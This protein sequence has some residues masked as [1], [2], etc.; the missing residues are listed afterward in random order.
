MQKRIYNFE[1]I[2]GVDVTSSPI[3]VAPNRAS[4]MINMISEGGTNKK[5]HGW[6]DVA[7]FDYSAAL[8]V[9]DINTATRPPI[10]GIFK[11]KDKFV[12]HAGTRFFLCEA[13]NGAFRADSLIIT[14]GHPNVENRKSKG[15]VQGDKLW[16][17]GAGDYLVYDGE[18]IQP[19]MNSE[20]AFIPTTTVGIKA[21]EYGGGGSR[22]Q[23]VNLL[24]KRRKNKLEGMVCDAGVAY[25]YGYYYLDAEFDE[26]ESVILTINSYIKKRTFE[27]RDGSKFEYEGNVCIEY[28]GSFNNYGNFESTATVKEGDTQLLDWL[29]EITHVF[30]CRNKNK[31]GEVY[32]GNFFST[33]ILE[34]ES[35]I[36]VEFTAKSEKSN[37]FSCSTE[38]DAGKNTLLAVVDEENTVYFSEFYEGYGYFPDNDFIC[39]GEANEPIT[40]LAPIDNCLGIFKKKALYRVQLNISYDDVNCITKTEYNLLQLLKGRG[41]INEYS[42]ASVNGDTVVYDTDGVFGIMASGFSK[43]SSN[44]DSEITARDDA[45]AVSYEGRY[46][47][48]VDGM[49]FIADSRFKYY[50]SNR[51]DSSYEYEWWVWDNCRCRCAFA[52]DGCLYMGTDDGKIRV[53]TDEYNDITGKY[54]HEVDGDVVRYEADMG[55]FFVFDERLKVESG[56]LFDLRGIY[57]K[58][59]KNRISI[60]KVNGGLLSCTFEPSDFQRVKD[61]VPRY[62]LFLYSKN[63]N[64]H[65]L[66]RLEEVVASER[67]L[68]FKCN[69]AYTVGDEYDLVRHATEYMIR[70]VGGG[71]ILS[72]EFNQIAFFTNQNSISGII[73]RKVPV[74]C[75][76]VTGAIDLAVLH[77]KSLYKLAVMPTSDTVG[78]ISFGYTTNYNNVEHKRQVGRAL[79]FSAFDFN[80]FVFDGAYFKTFIRRVF[81]RNFNLITLRFASSSDGPFGIE[82]AQ[83][84]Y[85]VNNELRGDL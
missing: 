79:D 80:T 16:I 73:K 53:F 68:V 83:A 20:Y 35:N 40:A 10:N 65:I 82:N 66:V 50:E 72:N 49:V 45:H 85:S 58:F 41:A 21:E 13:L 36:T 78:D 32:L 29:E 42:V 47:L 56:D 12:V 51:L 71:L 5:R 15:Y 84:V 63:R 70:G 24:Q 57:E 55:D 74:S 67:K 81:E 28:V 14:E 44:V 54:V 7:W 38:V 37:S 19:V 18:K 75:E 43:R 59:N 48:F 76:M 33:P 27:M 62:E 31:K 17:V 46:Y 25:R 3:N 39:V 64:V 77:S 1:K 26:S 34:N 22:L 61:M 52:I 4:Y 11:Y 8:D 30:S 60:E 9:E 2:R 23:A 6:E 69:G